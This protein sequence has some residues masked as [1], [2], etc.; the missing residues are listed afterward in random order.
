M[1]TCRFENSAKGTKYFNRRADK[2]WVRNPQTRFLF[3]KKKAFGKGIHYYLLFM[4]TTMVMT[5]R[6]ISHSVG[7]R[8]CAI[9]CFSFRPLLSGQC[10]GMQGKAQFLRFNL[11]RDTA[12]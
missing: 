10:Y 3:K 1:S 11:D 12:V 8:R 9:A 2:R 7:S 6:V 5:H 4:V